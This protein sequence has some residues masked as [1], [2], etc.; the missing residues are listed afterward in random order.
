VWL[1]HFLAQG[2]VVCNIS[3]L[4]VQALILQVI[5]ALRYKAFW[6][7]RTTPITIVTHNAMSDDYNTGSNQ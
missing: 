1:D 7:H 2:I 5:N 3:I 4:L 6:P